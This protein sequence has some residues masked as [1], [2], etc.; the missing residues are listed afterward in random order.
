MLDGV[1]YDLAKKTTAQ[2]EKNRKPRFPLFRV[3]ET[4][5]GRMIHQGPSGL[6]R[7]ILMICRLQPSTGRDN[8]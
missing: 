3:K 1:V 2:V 6:D 7:P 4:G 5:L 8:L